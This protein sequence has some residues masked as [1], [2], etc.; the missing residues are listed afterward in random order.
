[1]AADGGTTAIP[2]ESVRKAAERKS[3]NYPHPR[4]GA[5]VVAPI[6]RSGGIMAL[7]TTFDSETKAGETVVVTLVALGADRAHIVLDTWGKGVPV[8]PP[9]PKH[10][11]FDLGTVRR[12]KTGN[13]LTA[14]YSLLFV[15]IDI[16][17][18]LDRPKLALTL[19]V[20]KDDKQGQT[21]QLS[22]AE[23]HCVDTFLADAKFPVEGS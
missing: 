18:D 3:R 2:V 17:V 16:A 10:Q 4:C 11:A 5:T 20:G 8:K 22:E 1:M 21:F 12:G 19:H 23:F 9:S 13:R 6:V 15:K 14:V 7:S